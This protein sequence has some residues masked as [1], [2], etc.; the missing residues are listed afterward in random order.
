MEK[1][2]KTQK[3][4]TAKVAKTKERRISNKKVESL[5]K[6]WD[7][8]PGLKKRL[9]QPVEGENYSLIK[10]KNVEKAVK[11][12]KIVIEAHRSVG[13]S[14]LLASETL[15]SMLNERFDDS[16][17]EETKQIIKKEMQRRASRIPF[18]NRHKMLSDI[19]R[20]WPLVEEYHNTFK[21]GGQPA[22]KEHPLFICYMKFL[23]ADDMYKKSDNDNLLLH[24]VRK[25]YADFLAE[26]GKYVSL[27]DKQLCVIEKSK[28]L[29]QGEEELWKPYEESVTTEV[30]KRIENFNFYE[31]NL[32]TR[33]VFLR[34]ISF[35]IQ[36]Q[37]EEAIYRLIEKLS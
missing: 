17:L 2:N 22:C 31:T 27:P 24:Y 20:C 28:E 19:D 6:Y 25:V 30:N 33:M 4:K 36:L 21:D 29:Y 15:L 10:P 14:S 5:H 9:I 26:K 16:V 12:D 23:V 11:S 37:F 1:Q 32:N 34:D 8:F 7:A 3:S 35:N 18:V 13:I